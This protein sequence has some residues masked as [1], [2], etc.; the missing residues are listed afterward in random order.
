MIRSVDEISTNLA[1][2][3]FEFWTEDDLVS[4]VS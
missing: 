4:L 1:S 2:Y 3:G